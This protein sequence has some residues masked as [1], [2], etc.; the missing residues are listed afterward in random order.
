MKNALAILF[1][2]ASIV[3]IGQNN[4][5]AIN[6]GAYVPDQIE[7]VPASAKKMLINKL[8]QLVT[9]NGIS[10]N[11]YNSRFII[12]PNIV[13]ATKEIMPTAPVKVVL[14]LDVTLYIGDGISGTLYASETFNVKGV[15]TTETKAYMQALKRLKPKNEAMQDFIARGKDK[16]IDYYNTNCSQIQKEASILENSGQVEEALG[17]MLGIPAS[18]SCFEKSERKTKA[19]YIKAANRDCKMRLTEAQAIWSANQDIE[20][21]NEAA[22]ILSSVLPEAECFSQ[23]KALFS[24]IETRAKELQDRDWNYK[25]KVLDATK[26][27]YDSAFEVSMARAKN[28]PST[29]M[30]N[31]RG[32]Y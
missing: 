5:Y 24:K 18:S 6:L 9:A 28:Q 21:A 17:L 16:I 7:N 15:G 25:L 29:V 32:W 20:A 22:R 13:V 10:D 31:V 14:V 27:Y 30:Y 12:T 1:C 11:Q 3:A 26:S 23:V 4:D 2:F 8:G 19:L